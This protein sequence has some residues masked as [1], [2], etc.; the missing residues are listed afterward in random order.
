MKV[1]PIYK[2]NAPG[3]GG[4]LTPWRFV[5]VDDE[6]YERLKGYR[7][8]ATA[9]EHSARWNI[10]TSIWDYKTGRSKS[11][12]LVRLIL[13][14]PRGRSHDPFVLFRDENEFNCQKANLYLTRLDPRAAKRASRTLVRKHRIQRLLRHQKMMVWIEELPTNF[15]AEDWLREPEEI[16]ARKEAKKAKA[17]A[18]AT[19]LPANPVAHR[20]L[21]PSYLPSFKLEPLIIDPKNVTRLVELRHE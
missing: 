17:L 8:T 16:V 7:W 13:A 10:H 19:P 1:L 15:K 12:K 11:I 4:G 3:T 2:K 18:L 9:G 5:K 6:D 21:G 20:I 14:L